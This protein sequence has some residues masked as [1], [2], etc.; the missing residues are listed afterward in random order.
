[1]AVVYAHKM[2]KKRM[3]FIAVWYTIT[4]R[5]FVGLLKLYIYYIVNYLYGIHKAQIGHNTN[6]RP[7]VILREPRNIIIGSHCEFNNNSVL[8]G[9]RNAAKLRIGNYVLVGPNVAFYVSNHNTLNSGIPI[10]EQGYQEKDIIIEDDVWI[11]ANSVITSGVHIGTGAIIG[12]GSVV[13]RDI[14]P[15]CIAVGAPAKVIKHRPIA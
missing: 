12:A 9:G 14:P 4:L 2:S 15:Y 5:A 11:G 6:I 1:M 3:F 13:T 8:N 7:T 10:K